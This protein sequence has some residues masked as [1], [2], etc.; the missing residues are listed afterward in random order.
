[1]AG[2]REW[3]SHC[4]THLKDLRTKWCAPQVYCHTLLWAGICYQCAGNEDLPP[5]E[6]LREY[7]TDAQLWTHTE[8]HLQPGGRAARCDYP[9]CDKPE[10]ETVLSLRYH[11]IDSHRYRPRFAGAEVADEGDSAIFADLDGELADSGLEGPRDAGDSELHLGSDKFL[12]HSR[13]QTDHVNSEPRQ[14]VPW[15]PTE[16]M[17]PNGSPAHTQ[18]VCPRLLDQ[19]QTATPSG[20][21]S[22]VHT[23]PTLPIAHALNI[24][25]EEM[26]ELHPVESPSRPKDNLTSIDWSLPVDR[27]ADNAMFSELTCI[28][29]LAED[30]ALAPSYPQNS[31]QRP[32]FEAL[33]ERGGAQKPKILLRFSKHPAQ[34]RP[35]KESCRKSTKQPIGVTKLKLTL[36][37]K[38]PRIQ[39]RQSRQQTQ[40][41]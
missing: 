31:V 19:Y 30:A 33:G 10:F 37:Y 32:G 14:F 6:R 13:T 41:R 25:D 12:P 29:S 17:K 8:G 36:H 9:L 40:C 16:L 28:D 3:A 7:D 20:D 38:P 18:T 1:V 26:E 4:A 24:T 15:S 22:C 35:K 5:E 2:R 21:S 27:A 34:G 23:P 11:L 39:K